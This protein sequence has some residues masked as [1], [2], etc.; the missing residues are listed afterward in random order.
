[1]PRR[2]AI[3][4]KPRL[5]VE[6]NYTLWYRNSYQLIRHLR[7]DADAKKTLCS[8]SVIKLVMTPKDERYKYDYYPTKRSIK[9]QKD[10]IN[11]KSTVID[12]VTRKNGEL[13]INYITER[14][15]IHTRMVAYIGITTR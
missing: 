13:P 5:H 6:R 11:I 1:M 3:S 8:F 15:L 12:V 4:D 10:V 2:K 9:S 7:L 14:K